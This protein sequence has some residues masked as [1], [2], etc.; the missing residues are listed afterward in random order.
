MIA[1]MA[2]PL[3]MAIVLHEIAHGYVAYLKG[4]STARDMGRLTLNPLAHIDP[5]GTILM[6]LIFFYSMGVLFA[7]AKPVPVNFM[8]LH[9]PKEDMVWVAAAGPGMNL[10]LAII[11]AICIHLIS[12][13]AP[14]TKEYIAYINNRLMPTDY[15]IILFPLVGMLYFSVIL[16][17]VLAVINLIPIPP[18]DGGR[19][20]AGL[21]PPK[22]AAIYSQIE[23]FGLLILVG[24]IMFNPL[25]I[26]HRVI[27]PIIISI[28]ELLV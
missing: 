21:L 12:Y 7:F 4:D 5:F 8:N 3:V 15:S 16:N 27:W 17:V 18:A 2:L 11:S 20:V 6:P 13:A 1:V 10:F 23:P 24:I 28:V 14:E 19:I 22:Q 9:R 26:T 25:G